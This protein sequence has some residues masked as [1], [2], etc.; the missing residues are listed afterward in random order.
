MKRKLLNKA[1]VL[2]KMARR[3]SIQLSAV[4]HQLLNDGGA[5]KLSKAES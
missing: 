4:S 5:S 3:N 2:G 1:Q